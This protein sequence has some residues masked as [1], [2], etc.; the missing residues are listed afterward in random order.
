MALSQS[1]LKSTIQSSMVAAMGAPADPAKMELF[2]DGMA[3]ALLTILTSQAEVKV[4]VAGGSSSG[5]HLGVI[6]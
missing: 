3:Q 4:T 5:T 6:E 1:A 2:A